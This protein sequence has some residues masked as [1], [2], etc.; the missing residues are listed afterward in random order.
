MYMKIHDIGGERILAA[1]DKE[2]IGRKLSEGKM[3]IDI[4]K[5][6]S[7]YK[8]GEADVHDVVSGLESCTSAN[9]IGEKAVGCAISQGI[10][11]KSDVKMVSGVPVLMLF[12]ME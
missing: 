4:A 1:C 6:S 3:L 10:A 2:H 11:S 12:L 5:F 8:G 9:L 7:F